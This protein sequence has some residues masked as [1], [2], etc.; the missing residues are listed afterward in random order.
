MKAAKLIGSVFVLAVFILCSSGYVL[1]ADKGMNLTDTAKDIAANK[2]DVGK[3]PD[4]KPGNRFH[5][6]HNK[7]LGV[8]CT[9]CHIPKYAD[10]YLLIT[11][12]RPPENGAPGVIDRGMCLSCHKKNGPA[13]TKLYGSQAD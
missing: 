3:V 10:D 11:R 7:T 2:I 13:V 9:S 4:V 6:I 12:N 5:N 1:S 8:Q